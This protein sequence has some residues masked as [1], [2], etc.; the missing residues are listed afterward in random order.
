MKVLDLKP[1]HVLV[2][3]G[4]G[5]GVIAKELFELSGLNSPIWCVDPSVEMQEIAR[6]RKGIYTVLK[7]ANEFFSDPLISES[8]DRVI[9][10]T[11]AHH[12]VN[13]DV[14][15]KGILRSLRPGG[16]FVQ[17]NILNFGHPVFKCAEMPVRQSF[18]QE[19]TTQFSLL[20]R[21]DLNSKVSQEEFSFPLSLTKSKLYELFRWRYISVLE[22]FSDDQI[23]KG[24]KEFEEGLLKDVRDDELLN[25]EYTVLVTKAE[26]VS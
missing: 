8:F 25:Y 21:I 10:V 1:E 18:E 12:F 19:R 15:Y 20:G 16:M 26:K 24:I 4:S 14:V 3:I 23:E 7:T 11:S 13:P 9:A 17:I 22:Q 2:D 5:T 6:Q